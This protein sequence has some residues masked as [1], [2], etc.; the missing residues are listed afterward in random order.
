MWSPCNFTSVSYSFLKNFFGNLFSLSCAANLSDNSSFLFLIIFFRAALFFHIFLLTLFFFLN[1]FVLHLFL[2]YYL[3]FFFFC[4]IGKLN[5]FKSSNVSVWFLL[6][7]T[8][9]ISKPLILST[10]SKFTSG[11]IICSLTPKL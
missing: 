6:V 8:I 4:F 7:V 10:L 5:S 11:K 1:S 3:S 9:V 2:P